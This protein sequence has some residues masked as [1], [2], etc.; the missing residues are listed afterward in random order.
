MVLYEC[1]LFITITPIA[2]YINIVM[3]YVDVLRIMID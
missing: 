3:L 2:R 1:D